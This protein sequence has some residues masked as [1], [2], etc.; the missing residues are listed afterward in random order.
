MMDMTDRSPHDG[1]AFLRACINRRPSP[2]RAIYEVG[3]QSC[4]DI[5]AAG[6][7]SPVSIDQMF[8][9]ASP[10]LHFSVLHKNIGLM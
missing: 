10:I 6:N 2:V 9:I 3:Q 5:S 1:C 7:I 8:P 4:G